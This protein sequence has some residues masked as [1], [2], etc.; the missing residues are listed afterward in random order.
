[1]LDSSN[2]F[3]HFF[4]CFRLSFIQGLPISEEKVLQVHKPAQTERK[5]EA[6]FEI[7]GRKRATR[8]A[9]EIKSVGN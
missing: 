7:R 9:E 6:A 3:S 8:R 4:N 5:G 1:M 2:D